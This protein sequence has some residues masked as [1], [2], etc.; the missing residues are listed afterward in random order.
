[1]PKTKFKHSFEVPVTLSKFQK[2]A[3]DRVY[4]NSPQVQDVNGLSQRKFVPVMLYSN[5]RLGNYNTA[6]TKY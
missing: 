1:V 3:E 4:F 5:N 2:K 6:Q